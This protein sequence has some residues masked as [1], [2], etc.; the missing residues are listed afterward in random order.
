MTTDS[1]AHYRFLSPFPRPILLSIRDTANQP[2]HG[3]SRR[4][5]AAKDNET[6]AISIDGETVSEP[7]FVLKATLLFRFARWL[8]IHEGD[9]RQYEPLFE[10]SLRGRVVVYRLPC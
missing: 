4:A 3:Q 9:L 8:E 2:H 6:W 10:G 5:V 7:V 1:A